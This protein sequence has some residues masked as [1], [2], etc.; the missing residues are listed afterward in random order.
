MTTAERSTPPSGRVRRRNPGS[1]A[2]T[3]SRDAPRSRTESSRGFID[4]K[5]RPEL[6]VNPAIKLGRAFFVPVHPAA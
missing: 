1:P 6:I 2:T 5:G 4:T 3:V